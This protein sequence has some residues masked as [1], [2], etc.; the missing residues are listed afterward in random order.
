MK[1]AVFYRQ[2]FAKKIYIFS[3]NVLEKISISTVFTS[4]QKV[5]I[6]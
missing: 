4:F 3:M 5:A 6:F 2:C 1:E